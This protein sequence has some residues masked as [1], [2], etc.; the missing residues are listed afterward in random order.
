MQQIIYLSSSVEYSNSEEI[1][2]LLAQ[3]R[4]NSGEKVITSV[5]IY[6]EGDFLQIIEGPKIAVLN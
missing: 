1:Q 2:S 5:L 4:K 3:S 6:V